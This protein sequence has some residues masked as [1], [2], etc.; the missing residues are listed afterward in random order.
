MRKFMRE[1]DSRKLEA[2]VVPKEGT[3]AARAELEAFFHIYR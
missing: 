1:H 2:Q 3:G